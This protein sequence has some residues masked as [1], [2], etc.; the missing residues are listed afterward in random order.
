MSKLVMPKICIYEK[1]LAVLQ[2][3]DKHVYYAIRR[4][5]KLVYFA[6]LH[7]KAVNDYDRSETRVWHFNSR[8]KAVRKF[9]KVVG[10][11]MGKV[12]RKGYYNMNAALDHDSIYD[13]DVFVEVWKKIVDYNKSNKPNLEKKRV[14]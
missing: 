9:D 4:V 14:N 1:K 12:S 6:C 7:A 13:K 10:R 5:G 3:D 2:F 8:L 11:V